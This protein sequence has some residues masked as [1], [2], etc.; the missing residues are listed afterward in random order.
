MN[1]KIEGSVTVC[2]CM[3]VLEAVKGGRAQM[4][5]NFHDRKDF[6]FYVLK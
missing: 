1:K 2:V 4:G 3:F 5:I 6:F